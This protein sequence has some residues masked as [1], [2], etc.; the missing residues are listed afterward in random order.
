MQMQMQMLLNNSHQQNKSLSNAAKSALLVQV[1]ER[2]G[3]TFKPTKRL[4]KVAPHMRP[5]KSILRALEL[6]ES[7]FSI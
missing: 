4:S 7:N 5:S 1:I 6:R 2:A 3:A